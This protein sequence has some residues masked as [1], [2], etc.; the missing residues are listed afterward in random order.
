MIKI[1]IVDDHAILRAGIRVLLQLQDDFDVVGEA[2]N[3]LEAIQQA[4]LLSPD[5]VLMDIG[6]PGMD[7]LTASKVLLSVM[8]G[9]KIIILTQHENK[10]YVLPAMK[11]G[12]VG[13]VLKRAPDNTLINAIREVYQGGTYVDQSVSGIILEDVR[14]GD[15]RNVTDPYELLTERERDV[16]ILLAK[17]KTYQE[18]A[19]D[20]FITAKTV[21]FHRANFMRKL[22]LA[23]RSD[24][25]RFAL[26]RGLI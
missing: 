15:K 6:L 7:G 5:I 19:D 26:K 12:A 11:V 13:Y 23:N 25:V 8:P 9:L 4:Q 24:I 22:N 21:D 2:A 18:V 1:L 14:R 3:A 10:E 17:G 16:F 20:L